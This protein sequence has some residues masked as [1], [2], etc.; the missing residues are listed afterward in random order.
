MQAFPLLV[1]VMLLQAPTPMPAASEFP[2]SEAGVWMAEQAGLSKKAARQRLADA[3]EDPA[4][5]GALLQQD[6]IDDAFACLDRIVAAHP[7]R[8]ADA[9]RSIG[10]ARPRVSDGTHD[11]AARLAALV[12]IARGRIAG[13]ER[14]DRALAEYEL[15]LADDIAHPGRARDWPQR[16][17]AFIEAYGETPAGMSARILATEYLNYRDRLQAL[18]AIVREH[19]GS[20]AAAQ[21]LFEKAFQLG[22]NA[23][24]AGPDV[25]RDPTDR[26][27]E[28]AAIVRDLE[29]GRY[30]PCEWV[31]RAPS[32]VT[33]FYAFRPEIAPANIDRMLQA[34]LEF[35][36][37]HV[38]ID[39]VLPLSNETGFLV[40]RKMG[41]LYAMKGDTDGVDRTFAELEQTAPEPDAVR[42]ARA[43]A[44]PADE[45]I[46]MLSELAAR[47]GGLYNRKALATLAADAMAARRYAEAR[48]RYREYAT[49]YPES[50]YAWLASLRL[51]EA[52]AALDDWAS[53]ASAA[54][55]ATRDSASGIGPVLG[56]E[57]AARAYEARGDFARALTEHAA[58]LAAWD[59][60]FGLSY[61]MN[62]LDRDPSP[63]SLVLP[64][65]LQ[66]SDLAV[67]VVEMRDTLG[68]PG[69]ALFERGR[70]RLGSRDYQAALAALA[71][72]VADFPR[73]TLVPRA[74]E[75]SH[76][77]ELE[78]ALDLAN[79]ERPAAD[80]AAARRALDVLAR[81]PF[82]AA[83]AGAQIARAS[84]EWTAGRT[85][86]A[87]AGLSAALGDW[88]ARQPRSVPA[89]DLERDVQAIRE[90]AFLPQGGGI[91]ASGGRWNAFDW[92]ATL[93]RYLIMNAATE[94]KLASGETMKVTLRSPFRSP[95]N[96]IFADP[97][98]LALLSKILESLG[99][100]K[101]GVP[102]SVMATP[103]QPIGES[104]H[105]IQLWNEFFPCRPGHWM[106]WEFVSYP[107][108]DRIE[109]L[110]AARTRAAVAVT[111]GYSGATVVMEKTG[112]EWHAVK[113]TNQWI[114]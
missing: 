59:G 52:Y 76:R 104:R 63:G 67:R 39:T 108:I 14:D 50:G 58:A 77:I 69:G 111:I 113:L 45:R 100:T 51:S 9:F 90:T 96:V 65:R 112:N 28:V 103:N 97:D 75:L 18:D 22:H 94:V 35:A 85:N 68:A 40:V 49:R 74:L 54:K 11:Y 106:G 64:T 33:D 13:L 60:D 26:L 53:A 56:H 6:D 8:I 84:M 81:E 10:L 91:Y 47:G 12:G 1:A 46:A 42:Y 16:Q 31:T 41:E 79:G 107:R 37:R 23:P 95:S 87:R 24:V 93:P 82:D 72:L 17:A 44:R 36:K 21:A 78:R 38:R 34:Y 92:P 4:T 88:L 109:F 2:P 57:A 98:Q 7:E 70:S 43:L 66:K 15:M 62:R 110:D 80:A 25:Q 102:S 29:S 73:S 89:T 105:I 20:A 61:P 32:L 48:D 3:P 30:P 55:Q 71:K 114:T 5:V 83:V 19:P 99:G 101:K 86:A 27:L